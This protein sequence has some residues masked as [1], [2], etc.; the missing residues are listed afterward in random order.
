MS[1]SEESD[2]DTK[3]I[4]FNEFLYAKHHKYEWKDLEFHAL[5]K[6]LVYVFDNSLIAINEQKIFD[7]WE[8]DFNIK[9]KK[10]SY[11]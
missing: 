3:R 10:C 1:E 5:E 11:L 2:N 8:H 9:K 7:L 6:N 4:S